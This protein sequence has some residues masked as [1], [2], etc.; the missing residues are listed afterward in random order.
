LYPEAPVEL[1]VSGDDPKIALENRRFDGPDE[2]CGEVFE[3]TPADVVSDVV[4]V[5]HFLKIEHKQ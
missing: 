2:P 4:E 5:A 3:V 1:D